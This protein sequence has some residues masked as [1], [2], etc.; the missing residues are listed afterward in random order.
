MNNAPELT[1]FHQNAH[2]LILEKAVNIATMTITDKAIAKLTSAACPILKDLWRLV[3]R[4]AQK[5]RRHEN[6]N[7]SESKA[8]KSSILVSVCSATLAIWISST[9][10]RQIPTMIADTLE[11]CK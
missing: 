4:K 3:E 11:I 2:L 5:E 1:A 10:A 7:I 6:R 8:T 9:P